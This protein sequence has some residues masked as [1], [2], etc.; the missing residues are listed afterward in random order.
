MIMLWIVVLP[1]PR[2][3]EPVRTICHQ[4]RW[5]LASTKAIVAE[6]SDKTL[7]PVV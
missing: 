7:E 2:L 6:L 1:S 3:L 4:R 5:D